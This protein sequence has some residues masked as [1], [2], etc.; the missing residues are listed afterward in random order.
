MPEA[1]KPRNRLAGKSQRNLYA[2][3]VHNPV[4]TTRICNKL[5]SVNWL[6]GEVA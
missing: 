6:T 3:R 2:H 5:R 1:I 4:N